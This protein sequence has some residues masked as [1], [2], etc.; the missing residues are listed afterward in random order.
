M[1]IRVEVE[2]VQLVIA[3][4]DILAGESPVVEATSGLRSAELIAGLAKARVPIG[5]A[6]GGHVK[7]SI[8]AKMSPMGPMVSGGGVRY[9]YFGW[10]DFGGRVGVHKSVFRRVLGTGRYIWR[11]YANSKHLVAAFMESAV[12]TAIRR[13]GLGG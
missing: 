3:R 9:P 12:D 1:S 7:G 5:P 2:G 8:S 13:S 6:L 4:L 11:S 10:L